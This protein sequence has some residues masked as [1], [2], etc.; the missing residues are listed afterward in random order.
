MEKKILIL[1]LS[2]LFISSLTFAVTNQIAE[3]KRYY[4]KNNE[5]SMEFPA[6]WEK[7]NIIE[8]NI[9]LV[10]VLPSEFLS[11][12]VSSNSLPPHMTLDTVYNKSI[13]LLQQSVNDFQQI[14]TGQINIAGVRTKWLVYSGKTIRGNAQKV[15]EYT[16][17]KD[18]RL[19]TITCIG[20]IVT[21]NRN[22]NTFKT[23]IQSFR[24]E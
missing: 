23:I 21:F 11:I 1:V 5:F 6:K 18:N 15:L 9:Y 22:P 13:N 19:Y 7:L 2:V 8:A 12:T 14:E 4:S 16:L 20:N 17:I 24:F 3:T 10:V